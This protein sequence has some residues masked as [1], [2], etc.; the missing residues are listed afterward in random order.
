MLLLCEDSD[1]AAKRHIATERRRST[2]I[3]RRLLVRFIPKAAQQRMVVRSI[4]RDTG[5]QQRRAAKRTIT[6]QRQ[7][8]RAAR[9]AA[10]V[11][12]CSKE[13][14]FRLIFTKFGT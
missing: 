9:I 12:N 6:V 8:A 4:P 10:Y 5:A 14:I 2:R 1:C 3:K 11:L 7:R 13:A